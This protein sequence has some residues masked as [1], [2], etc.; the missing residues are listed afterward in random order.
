MTPLNLWIHTG[1]SVTEKADSLVFS[2]IAG[3][4]FFCR[5]GTQKIFVFA[6]N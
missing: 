2:Q 5:L 6:L 4:F 3:F 1:S